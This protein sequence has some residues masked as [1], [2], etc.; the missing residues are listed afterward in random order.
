MSDTP[1]ITLHD[2]MVRAEAIRTKYEVY[3]AKNGSEAWHIRDYAMAFGGDFGDLMK[4][5]M[6]KENLRKVD[7]VDDKLGRELADC[8]WSILVLASY[9]GID[10][11]NEFLQT[12]D[13]ITKRITREKT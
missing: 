5:V 3:N 7:S 10:L 6:A 8:L 4:L 11:E 12:M 2:L 13:A 9:Y 1:P